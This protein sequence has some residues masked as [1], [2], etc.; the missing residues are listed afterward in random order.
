MQKDGNSAELRSA[1]LFVE[2]VSQSWFK[3]CYPSFRLLR[4][5]SPS[6]RHRHI[7]KIPDNLSNLFNLHYLD[8]G[9]TKLKEIPK[10][11]GKLRNL[12]TLYL[13]RVL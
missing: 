5:L 10:S 7:Q 9:Y 1:I 3:E 11:I 12:Q 8:L 4:V 2:E 13:T 6:P